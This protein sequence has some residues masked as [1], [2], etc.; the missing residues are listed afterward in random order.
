MGGGE[1]LLTVA[2][3]PE[4][5]DAA[6]VCGSSCWGIVVDGKGLKELS[7]AAIANICACDTI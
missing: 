6:L 7:V 3:D 2:S 1:P 4:I 5:L